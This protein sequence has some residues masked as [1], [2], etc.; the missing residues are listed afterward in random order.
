MVPPKARDIGCSACS[1]P[2]GER[3]SPGTLTLNDA[4]LKDGK[5]PPP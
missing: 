5:M 2:P 1:Y 4:G 3:N